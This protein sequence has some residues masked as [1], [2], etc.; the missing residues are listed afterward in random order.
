MIYKLSINHTFQLPQ[1]LNISDL[2]PCLTSMELKI[3]QF[4]KNYFIYEKSNEFLSLSNM[5]TQ[6]I[7]FHSLVV[8]EKIQDNSSAVH[9]RLDLSRIGILRN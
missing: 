4:Y 3:W 5:F 6:Q 8:V 1:L 2:V 9:S 7:N